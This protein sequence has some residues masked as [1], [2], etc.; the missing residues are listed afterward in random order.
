MEKPR[1][2]SRLG[3]PDAHSKLP[4]VE[5]V[6]YC[7]VLIENHMGV[8]AYAQEEISVRV[9]YGCL[10]ITGQNMMLAE[11]SREQLVITGQIEGVTV[12]RR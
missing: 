1:I 10:Q 5:M 8:L 9:S 7:R 12:Y 2:L 11:M 6:G 3:G 4:L